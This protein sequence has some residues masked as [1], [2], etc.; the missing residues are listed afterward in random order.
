[1]LLRGAADAPDEVALDLPLVPQADLEMMLTDFNDTMAPF[2]A[3]KTINQL[4]EAHAAAQPDTP[5]LRD[6]DAVLTY[7]EVCLL[8][9]ACQVFLICENILYGGSSLMLGIQNLCSPLQR[10]S[11]PVPGQPILL[12]ECPPTEWLR[13]D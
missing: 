9:A 2:P 8:L 13:A 12:K 6:G 3:D 10:P 11:H 1:M 5:C 4:F 7:A